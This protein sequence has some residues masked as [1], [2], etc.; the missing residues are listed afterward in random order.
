MA[1]RPS[2]TDIRPREPSL[3][4]DANLYL[5]F[6]VTLF[7]VMGVASITPAFPRIIS[8]FALTPGQIG[9]LI[10]VFTLPGVFFA[11][12]MG[13]LAD[14][15]GRKAILIPSLLLFG[16]A[17]FLCAF[18]TTYE[19]LLVL[20]LFQGMGAAS[21]GSLNVTIIGDLYQERR[22]IQAMGY[23]A[24]VLSIGTAA[25]PALGGFL[26][27]FHWRYAFF[28][29]G[30]AALFA[31]LIAVRLRTPAVHGKVSLKAYLGNAWKTVNRKKVWGLF[32]VNILLFI[33]VYG[34]YLSFFPI[35]LGT[36][37]QAGPLVIG[38]SMS[39]M[40]V[41]TAVCSSQLGRVRKRIAAHTLLYI[42]TLV[43][44]VSLAVLSAAAGWALVI[45]GIVLF[46][47][48]HG[49][50]IPNIQTALVG[51]ASARERA[52]FMAINSMVLRIGQTLGPMV[53]A[54]FYAGGS[55]RTVY[56]LSA[57]IP[58]VMLAV[59]ILLVGPVDE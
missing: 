25:F 46:G 17:G 13:I 8:H 59:L 42:S 41:V 51:L 29:P 40:S 44:T 14:R 45:A 22:R 49:F 18:Q 33:L 50:F 6:T 5:I 47:T 55:V 3:F 27:S 24:S 52:A 35:F 38:M 53:I 20:R 34:A 1:E 19:R 26:A 11:P 31:V 9:Y 56:L 36:R 39:L 2:G 48:A 37:F 4:R 12:A 16:I 21:L 57:A 43:Y 10:T 15:Y 28:L 54:L 23:N 30:F 7:A 58:L 32:L